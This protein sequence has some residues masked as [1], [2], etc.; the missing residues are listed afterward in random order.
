MASD[1]GSF[2]VRCRADALL[3]CDCSLFS[4]LQRLGEPSAA[5]SPPFQSWSYGVQTLG[6]QKR[7]C[8]LLALS[9]GESMCET[10][11]CKH[12]EISWG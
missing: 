1:S 4:P 9:A 3:L 6:T 7:R 10:G 8:H 12:G 5:E 11:V 2:S